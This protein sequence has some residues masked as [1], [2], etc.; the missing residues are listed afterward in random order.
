MK[1]ELEL[2]RYRTVNPIRVYAVKN[3][4]DVIPLNK[5]GHAPGTFKAHAFMN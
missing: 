3:S 4:V 1:N 2:Q 5:L